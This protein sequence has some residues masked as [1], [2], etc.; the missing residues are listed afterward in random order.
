[1][2]RYAVVGAGW[3]S[4]EAFVPGAAQSGNSRVSAI[5][6]GDLQKA[7]R[8]AQFHEI[9]QVVSYPASSIS[10]MWCQSMAW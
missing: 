7:S 9:P 5:V 3:I 2:I 1:M 6:T 10:A 4:Q 8:L